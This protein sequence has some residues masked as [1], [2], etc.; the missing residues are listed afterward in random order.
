MSQKLVDMFTNWSA[1]A[2]TICTAVSPH[3]TRAAGNTGDTAKEKIMTL[4][5]EAAFV[6]KIADTYERLVKEKADTASPLQ[7]QATKKNIEAAENKAEKSALLTILEKVATAAAFSNRDANED[8]SARLLN[9]ANKFRDRGALLLG[10]LRQS[11]LTRTTDLNPFQFVSTMFFKLRTAN[12]ADTANECTESQKKAVDGD[13]VLKPQAY[14]KTE[15]K[16]FCI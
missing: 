7:K 2:I 6:L 4:C 10:R 14:G 8:S 12:A 16:N 11:S 13:T 3:T 15:L 9:A 1:I 5:Q